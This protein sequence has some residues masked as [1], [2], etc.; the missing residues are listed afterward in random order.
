MS[1]YIEVFF[2]TR[3][4]LAVR[5]DQRGEKNAFQENKGFRLSSVS[6]LAKSNFGLLIERIE[7]QKWLWERVIQSDKRPLK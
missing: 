7:L 2:K 1:D 6:D 4:G 5:E 3:R